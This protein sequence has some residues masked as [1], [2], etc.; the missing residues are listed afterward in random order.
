MLVATLRIVM[1]CPWFQSD[2]LPSCL[3]VRSL[4]WRPNIDR[5]EFQTLI[6]LEE[7]NGTSSRHS[8]DRSEFLMKTST[9]DLHVC[10]LRNG[11][12]LI[13]FTEKSC[14]CVRAGLTA[15]YTVSQTYQNNG[16]ATW[17]VL[18]PNRAVL[19]KMVKEIRVAGV[20]I[21]VEN[22]TPLISNKTLTKK[23]RE[24]LEIAYRRGFFD[25][26]RRATLRQLAE[27]LGVSR[28]TLME[29]LRRAEA[30]IMRER[31]SDSEPVEYLAQNN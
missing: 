6:E 27:E 30:R 21:F 4:A 25:V 23:Q 18:I 26:P 11:H 5:G 2:G 19:K 13:H 12:T 10:Q 20:N 3:A 22:I 24:L 28:S 29:S 9:P 17:R 16:T 1:P 15:L 7:Q 14:P 31:F 8:H